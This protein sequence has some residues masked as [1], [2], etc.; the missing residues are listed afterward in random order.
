MDSWNN[1]FCGFLTFY[2]KE[3]EKKVK[4]GIKIPPD[5]AKRAG[6]SV[7]L[8]DLSVITPKF[9]HENICIFVSH[10]RLAGKTYKK[11][12][13]PTKKPRFCAAFSYFRVGKIIFYTWCFRAPRFVVQ[14]P[15]KWYQKGCRQKARAFRA[16]DDWY[17][18]QGAGSYLA[19]STV[20]STW[21]SNRQP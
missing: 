2:N 17:S 5:R 19:F 8:T 11:E 6:F 18:L 14:P 13:K 9:F 3:Q 20:L 10:L 16:L 4:N 12:E 1:V 21:N 7:F 15:Q